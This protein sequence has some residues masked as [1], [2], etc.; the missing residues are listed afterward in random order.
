MAKIQVTPE[1][2]RNR[3]Q[4]VNN[5]RANQD[6]AI[7]GINNSITSLKNIFMGA[8]S[9]AV[10]QQWP[11]IRQQSAELDTML[12]RMSDVMRQTATELENADSAAKA[13]ILNG[14]YGETGGGGGG[15]RINIKDVFG[16][17]GKTVGPTGGGRGG[18][19]VV[20]DGSL[21]TSGLGWFY[22]NIFTPVSYG[23]KGVE[24]IAVGTTREAMSKAVGNA[25]DGA[26]V[27]VSGIKVG[28]AFALSRAAGDSM[29]RSVGVAAGET[30]VQG[31]SFAGGKVGAAKG[32]ATGAKWGMA[33]GPK[34]AAVGAVVGGIVGGV[35]GSGVGRAAGEFLRGG[36]EVIGEGV[37]NVMSSAVGG[38]KNIGRAIFNPP[39]ISFGRRR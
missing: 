18:A 32:A 12:R 31:S 16:P 22:N 1:L 15:G 33:L 20:Q 3:A 27:L 29:Q 21:P 19:N 14:L 39:R 10:F 36:A 28:S 9:G 25:F 2:L 26:S 13:A 17:G 30:V 23:W 4:E 34:G 6:T 11:G 7:G 38:I 37:A 35:V 8:A 5:L 24:G